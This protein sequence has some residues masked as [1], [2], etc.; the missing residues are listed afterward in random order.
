MEKKIFG[1]VGV[2]LLIVAIGFPVISATS[3]ATSES[4]LQDSPLYAVR[5]DHAKAEFDGKPIYQT[6]VDAGDPQPMVCSAATASACPTSLCAGSVCLGS[7]CLFSLCLG[8]LCLLSGCAGSM[9]IS[10]G[11]LDSYCMTSGCVG[12]YCASAAPCPE[13]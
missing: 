3:N 11:C 12:S 7:A 6:T 10:S 4:Q 8:S 13:C 1:I 5:T 2:L 9:C